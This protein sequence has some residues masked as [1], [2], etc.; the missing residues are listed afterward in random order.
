M[1]SEKPVVFISYA[2]ADGETARRL[3]NDLESAGVD[4]W[5]DE[6]ELKAGDPLLH[7]IRAGIEQ[8]DFLLV[9]VSANSIASKWVD[10][11]VR[12]AFEKHINTGAPAI[13][14]IRVDDT[15]PP[16]FLRSI[17]YVDIRSNYDEGLRQL[18]GA[19]RS[20]RPS[21]KVRNVIDSASLAEE[22]AK[23]RQSPRG[24]GFYVTT[25]LGIL[26]LIVTVFTAWPAFNQA[27]GDRPKIYFSVSQSQLSIPKSLDGDRIRKILRDQS[28]PDS[29][30]RIQVINR[31][32]KDADEIKIGLTIDG[33]LSS[34]ILEPDPT[35]NPV[36]VTITP[37]SL[38]QSD[39]SSIL[40]LK[41]L[42]PNRS[43]SAE[44]MYYGNSEKFSWDV[45]ADG[46]LANQVADIALVPQWS[47]WQE[48]KTPVLVFI[49]GT[50]LSVLIGIF[51][52]S[53]RNRMFRDLIL[54]VLHVV[55]PVSARLLTLL[56]K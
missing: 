33:N 18:L 14:P 32:A 7:T 15:E 36:W 26:T 21:E 50:V 56:T 55:S 35:T 34:S 51:V 49:V 2:S 8:S 39:K 25:I 54:E 13:I 23:E 19:L 12:E 46:L 9:L 43:F 38:K 11:E 6:F 31:G 4:T 29:N 30:V 27:F 52:A 17:K 28:I 22:L 40:V 44:Y 3:A 45:V 37:P 48:I 53:L 24:A 1:K 47:L 41:D 10:G 16:T 5:F 42:V 20:Q